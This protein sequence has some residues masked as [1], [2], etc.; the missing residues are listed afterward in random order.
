[1]QVKSPGL[2][3]NKQKCQVWLLKLRYV[4]T[5]RHTQDNP[6]LLQTLVRHVNATIGLD[7]M[8]T[9]FMQGPGAMP[10]TAR[11]I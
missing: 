4:E 5:T 1:M 8:L 3:V 10:S 9:N 11:S 6:D 2:H 7:F